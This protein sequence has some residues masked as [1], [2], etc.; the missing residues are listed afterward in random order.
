ME[1][2]VW[3]ANRRNFLDNGHFQQEKMVPLAARLANRFQR[4]VEL[5]LRAM[6]MQDMSSRNKE[7][8]ETE[9]ESKWQDISMDALTLNGLME[10]N[11]G[12]FSLEWVQSGTGMLRS[13]MEDANSSTGPGTVIW[14]ISPTARRLDLAKVVR[15]ATVYARRRVTILR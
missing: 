10:V 6:G 3:A 9:Q 13:S 14:C 7:S 2:L 1:G 15:K 8:F 12:L 11:S 4:A 5:Q